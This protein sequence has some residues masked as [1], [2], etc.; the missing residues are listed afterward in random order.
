MILNIYGYNLTRSSDRNKNAQ[1]F[2]TRYRGKAEMQSC[3]DN[4]NWLRDYTH[5]IT[6]RSLQSLYSLFPS[7]PRLASGR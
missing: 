5:K 7:R 3:T 4:V 1:F 2:E 6:L